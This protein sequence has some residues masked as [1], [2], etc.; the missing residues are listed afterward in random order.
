MR[1]STR[2]Q[3]K[4][5]L[6]DV[7]LYQLAFIPFIAPVIPCENV[8]INTEYPNWLIEASSNSDSA[9]DALLGSGSFWSPATIN[10]EY[11]SATLP[12]DAPCFIYS[13]ELE[14]A[15]TW[16]VFIYR[17]RF[18]ASATEEIVVWCTLFSTYMLCFAFLDT[19]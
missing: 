15:Q 17:G 6:T 14:V 11:W 4:H 3:T 13:I 7:Q 8:K 12:D 19:P 5:M 9:S 1:I 16:E 18:G 2:Y 10:I